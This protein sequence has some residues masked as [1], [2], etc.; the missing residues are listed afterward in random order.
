MTFPGVNRQPDSKGVQKGASSEASLRAFGPNTE[1]LHR[2]SADGAGAAMRRSPASERQRAQR[3]AIRTVL[4]YRRVGEAEWRQGTMV[5]ISESGVL[6][7]TDHAAW[8][9]STVEIRFNLGAVNSG[10]WAAQVVCYGVIVRALS[11]PG[12]ARVSGLAARITKFHFVRS[13]RAVVA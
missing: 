5:N 7:E 13:G 9:N 6:F 2:P 3:F 4:R 11:K 10:N 1:E 12:S 8:P